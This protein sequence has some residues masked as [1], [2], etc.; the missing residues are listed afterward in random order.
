MNEIQES[1][2]DIYKQI[3]R[4]CDKNNLPFYAIG[5]TCIGAVRH[6]GFIP[7]DDDM[8]IAVPIECWD[9]FWNCMKRELPS[10]YE[11]YTCNKIK[12][13]RYI[14]NKIHN[15]K[16]T[17]IEEAEVGY[18]DAYKGIYV[19]VM[20][21]AGMPAEQEL[22]A[23]FINKIQMYAKLNFVRRYPFREM[24]TPKSRFAWILLHLLSPFLSYHYFSDKWLE[25]L[26]RYPLKKARYTGYTWWDSITNKLCFPIEYFETTIELPF[27]D[28]TISCPVQSKDYL[29]SQFGNY[30]ELP[31]EDQRLDHHQ[32][33]VS[34][35]KSYK[36][37]KKEF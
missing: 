26:K 36:E 22:R 5:G 24:K 19:D 33:C 1:I 32:V 20:P 34:T 23:K 3:K 28:S 6:K 9:E 18:P 4:I 14:F 11:I 8:D 30:M 7:W 21:I 35:N 17:F 25:M 29:S 12:H 2:L 13:Y 37:Y 10:N 31:P 15:A 27:E 16:T